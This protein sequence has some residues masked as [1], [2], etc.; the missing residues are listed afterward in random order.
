MLRIRIGN[1]KFW[2]DRSR[3]WNR[4]FYLRFRNPAW[5]NLRWWTIT[6]DTPVQQRVSFE[7]CYFASARHP[8]SCF[9][10]PFYA[11][12]YYITPNLFSVKRYRE[13]LRH[14]R[15]HLTRL[16]AP[17]YRH[18]VSSTVLLPDWVNLKGSVGAV[19]EVF[20]CGLYHVCLTCNNAATKQTKEHFALK[21]K[22]LKW[23]RKG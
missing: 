3:S 5:N 19:A 16:G 8:Q 1:R 10:I 2:K 4:M 11:S 22:L 20:V 12:W 7:I 9:V 18:N 14:H 13:L 23:P 6:V 21:G 17:L 15:S